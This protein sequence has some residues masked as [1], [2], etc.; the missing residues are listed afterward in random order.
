MAWTPEGIWKLPNVIEHIQTIEQSLT[1]GHV[2]VE[3]VKKNCI[4]NRASSPLEAVF[5]LWWEAHLF[6]YRSMTPMHFALELVPQ[7]VVPVDG[8]NYRLDFRVSAAYPANLEKCALRLGVSAPLIGVELDGHE[9]HERTKEQATY[10]N[11]RDRALQRFGWHVFHVSG[12]ELHAKPAE[13]VHE[14]AAHAIGANDAFYKALGIR[15]LEAL[16]TRRA[17]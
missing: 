4:E 15:L 14:I 17:N 6:A 16:P 12:S 2:I 9:F 7:H 3:R 10:R 1:F 8:M 11:Q 5:A 13:T